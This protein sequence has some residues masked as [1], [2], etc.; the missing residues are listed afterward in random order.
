MAYGNTIYPKS[1]YFQTNISSKSSIISIYHLNLKSKR[2]FD[3]AF[4]T[5]SHQIPSVFKQTD[6]EM[7]KDKP[8][9]RSG[10]QPHSRNP[11]TQISRIP[12]AEQEWVS[13]WKRKKKDRI[14]LMKENK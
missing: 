6:L 13:V 12:L 14:P 11:S 5:K 2:K 8:K 9:T 10:R 4:V 1:L 7:V 3:S